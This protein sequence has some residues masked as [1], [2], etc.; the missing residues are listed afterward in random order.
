M[1]KNNDG[2]G[3]GVTHDEIYLVDKEELENILNDIPS[4]DEVSTEEVVVDD[5]LDELQETL[6]QAQDELSED[7]SEFKDENGNISRDKINDHMLIELDTMRQAAFGSGNMK[8]YN[9]I[10]RIIAEMFDSKS[11]NYLLTGVSK[12]KGFLVKNKDFLAAQRLA[13][14]KLSQNKKFK[15]QDPKDLEQVLN[16]VLPPEYK[17][18][19]KNFL[20]RL[21]THVNTSKMSA[22]AISVAQTIS[23][24]Y[25]LTKGDNESNR[26]FLGNVIEVV[27]QTI[28]KKP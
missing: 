27:K 6:A 23:N 5:E 12:K 9:K 13:S 20:Y 18:Y 24:V 10:N 3:T 28:G 7:L 15:F 16:I 14:M 11:L 25:A 22:S 1:E 17:P 4:E 8:V 19:A 2:I 21:Y 26:E